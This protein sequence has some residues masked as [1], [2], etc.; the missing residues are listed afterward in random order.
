MAALSG[1][2]TI[3]EVRKRQDKTLLLAAVKML[4]PHILPS[5]IILMR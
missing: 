5:R 4:L 3:K 1:V 2:E